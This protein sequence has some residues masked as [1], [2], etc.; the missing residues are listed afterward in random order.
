MVQAKNT[1]RRIGLDL[2]DEKRRAITS[3]NEKGVGRD[4]LSVLMRSNI[5]S[6]PSQRMSIEE[7]LCQISTFLAAGHETTCS[8]LTWCLYALAKD[9][10]VQS[11]LRDTLRGIQ[12]Q[13]GMES[14]AQ[15]YRETLTNQI[16][17]CNYLD[18]VVRECLRLHAPVTNTMRVC[19]RDYD[20]I[21][22]LNPIHYRTDGNQ[23]PVTVGLTTQ[24]I[25]IRKWD[26]ISVPIQAINKGEMFWGKD[27]GAFR[28]E[29]WDRPPQG[30]RLIPGLY[31]TFLNG[32]RACIGYKFSIFEIKIFLYVL[33][34][35]AA[36]SID[37]GIFI[38]KKV[39][40]VAR[41][42]V[43]HF[44]NQLPLNISRVPP[45]VDSGDRNR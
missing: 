43:K 16:M 23:D 1:M 32:K 30:A 19:M 9:C 14:G 37:S 27:A 26:I 5:S 33:I 36:F 12:G 10:R 3:E 38:Q 15:D 31:L 6:T 42:F 20:E 45:G 2:I 40:I 17:K 34:K 39:N 41:P 7:V 29:R 11:K 25:P 22:V 18:W 35:D 13:I 28:P 44:G 21:P 24:T 4:L 8:A